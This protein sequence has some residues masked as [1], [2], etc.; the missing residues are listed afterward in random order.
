MPASGRLPALVRAFRAMAVLSLIT[1]FAAIATIMKAESMAKIHAL[2]AVAI[3]L[4]SL[5]LLG[6]AVLALPYAYRKRTRMTL[7]H[8]NPVSESFRVRAISTPT[9]TSSAAGCSPRWTSRPA[10]SPR[11]APAAR[12]PRSRSSGWEFIAPIHLRDVI[13]VFAEVERVAARRWRSA[14]R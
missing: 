9:A 2:I 13:S 7:D 3:M 14:S 5:A 10:S 8:K 4:G 1:A 12:S 11:A 6:L